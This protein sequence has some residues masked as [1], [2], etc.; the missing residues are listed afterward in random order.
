MFFKIVLVVTEA[1]FKW[2]SAALCI[3]RLVHADEDQKALCDTVP[4]VFIII[5]IITVYSIGQLS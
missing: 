1:D 2:F 3:L 5:T 4:S